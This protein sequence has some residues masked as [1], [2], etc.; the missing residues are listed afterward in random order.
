MHDRKHLSARFHAVVVLVSVQRVQNGDPIFN[1]PALRAPIFSLRAFEILYNCIFYYY[2]YTTKLN[3]VCS[4]L[5]LIIY[6]NTFWFNLKVRSQTVMIK[7]KS[8]SS[9]SKDKG[10]QTK[11][12]RSS[13]K[14]LGSPNQRIM[15]PIGLWLNINSLSTVPSKDT[16]GPQ[17]KI[18]WIRCPYSSKR[19]ESLNQN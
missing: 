3:L 10:P 13:T 16:G 4:M 2:D 7:H 8:F 12:K 9:W 1:L 11:C 19:H 15:K 5:L 14:M 17:K 6:F 18:I